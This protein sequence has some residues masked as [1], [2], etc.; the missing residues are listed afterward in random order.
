MKF[1][2]NGKKQQKIHETMGKI[3]I[4]FYQKWQKM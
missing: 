2:Q 1:D 4:K 3:S